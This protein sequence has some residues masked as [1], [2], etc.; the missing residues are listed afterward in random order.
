MA[1]EISAPFV[2]DKK[3]SAISLISRACLEKFERLHDILQSLPSEEAGDIELDVHN[4]KL[5]IEDALARFKAWGTNIAAFRDGNLRISLDF[6]LREAPRVK[7]RALRILR[8][9]EEYLD[10]GA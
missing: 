7:G 3:A 9:L 4:A 1:G 6:R 8:D 10:D 2:D 5:V